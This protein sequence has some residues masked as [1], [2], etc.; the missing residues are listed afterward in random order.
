LNKTASGSVTVNSPAYTGTTTV[1]AGTLEFTGG[2]PGGNYVISGGTLDINDLSRSIGTFQLTSG[3]VNGTGTLTSSSAYNLQS[4]TV[5]AVLGGNV[6]LNKTTAGTVSLTGG[7]PGGNYSI[8]DGTLDIN[9]LSQTIGTFQITGGTVNGTGTLTSTTASY[10]VRA[11][12]VGVALVGSRGLDKTTSGSA[13]VNNPA[14]TGTT[15][16]SAGTLDFT[17]VLPGGNYVISGGTLD[18]NNLSQSIGTFQITGGTVGG[19]GTLTSNATFD[20]RGGTVQTVL[21][22]SPG[23]TKIQNTTATLEGDNQYLGPTTISAGTLALA[24][25]GQ[26]S[27]LSTIDNNATFLI[28]D[29]VAPHTVGVITGAGTT[30]LFD[31]ARLTASSITQGTLAI[32]G[33]G[34]AAGACAEAGAQSVPEPSVW[35]LLTLAG[36]G[37][38]GAAGRRK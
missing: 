27:P 5:G 21:A 32:G 30:R 29:G 34:A 38:L 23:L 12:T 20:I 36:L 19:A 37:L 6:G 24:N 13:T 18:I 11:G 22:G 2:L 8:S 25:D 35:I 1:S 28:A 14:Y 16:V 15:T 33:S 4:G 10:D 7:L 17:G 3:T 9:N 26:I 31:G